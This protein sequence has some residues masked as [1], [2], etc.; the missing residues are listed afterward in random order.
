[1]EISLH[2]NIRFNIRCNILMLNPLLF[3]TVLL[4][5]KTIGFN[6]KI[7]DYTEQHLT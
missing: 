1:M 6:I 2:Y 4:N 5:Y 7:T 3:Y